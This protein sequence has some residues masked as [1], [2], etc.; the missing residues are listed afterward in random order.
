[1]CL[2]EKVT[3]FP[4]FAGL[5]REVLVSLRGKGFNQE[6]AR[7]G[8]TKMYPSCVVTTGRATD[9]MRYRCYSSCKGKLIERPVEA[10]GGFD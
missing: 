9:Y 1:M 2:S 10:G 4:F 3:I 6:E 8:S 7:L 5:D